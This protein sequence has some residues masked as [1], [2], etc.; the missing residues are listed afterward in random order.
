MIEFPLQLRQQNHCYKVPNA[1]VL[2]GFFSGSNCLIYNY[3]DYYDDI[4]CYH[5]TTFSE[6]GAKRFIVEQPHGP[7]SVLWDFLADLVRL[8]EGLKSRAAETL[9][10]YK[11]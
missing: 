1:F 11:I 7:I 10:D 2:S 3:M 8:P 9:E 6:N 4:I 5:F